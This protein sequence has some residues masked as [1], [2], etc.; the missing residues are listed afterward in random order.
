MSCNCFCL[1]S[2]LDHS[3]TCSAELYVFVVGRDDAR[4]GLQILP[5]DLPEGSC[6]CAV[7]DAD[8]GGIDQKSIV[9]EVGDCLQ[10]FV[11]SHA[12]NIYL[13]SEV[14]VL[15]S[16]AV[17]R[18]SAHYH[19]LGCLVAFSFWRKWRGFQSLDIY[20]RTHYAECDSGLF[21]FDGGDGAN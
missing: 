5:N 8:A 16:D 12:P 19:G 21:A 2:E 3:N 9:D 4:H 11:S 20:Q 6:A 15:L 7:K 13:L 1:F 17:L 14:K 18:L 10:C